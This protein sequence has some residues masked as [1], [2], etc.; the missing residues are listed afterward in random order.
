M[1]SGPPRIAAVLMLMFEE[2]GEDYVIFTRRTEEVKTHKGQIS[3]PGGH[4]EAE[5]ASLVDT[6]LRETEEELGIAPESILIE[7]ELPEVF[8][9]VS[10]F[11]IKPYVG[12]VPT[13]P[14][15]VP[16]PIEVAEVIEVPLTA[17]RNPDVYW[18]ESRSGPWGTHEVHFFRYG[19]YVIWGATGRILR[20]F[21]DSGFARM[22]TTPN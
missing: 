1:E 15:Y 9:V 6:A 2:N 7:G 13:R 11:L 14:A 10:N 8:T 20:H 22:E 19:D 17:L 5:D 12:T 16:D 3:F 21:L 18:T 4:R